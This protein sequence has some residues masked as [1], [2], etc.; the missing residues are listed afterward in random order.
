MNTLRIGIVKILNLCIILY[1]LNYIT[2]FGYLFIPCKTFLSPVSQYF[3][4]KQQLLFGELWK[5]TRKHKSTR[6]EVL[7]FLIQL[8]KANRLRHASGP[9]HQPIRDIHCLLQLYVM[10]Y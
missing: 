4:L 10:G 9:I 2:S 5:R 3:I 8:T 7:R 1:V 6:K